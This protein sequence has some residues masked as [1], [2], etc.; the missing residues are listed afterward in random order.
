[1]AHDH[2]EPKLPL[3]YLAVVAY[4]ASRRPQVDEAF[5]A[6][7]AANGGQELDAEAAEHEWEQRFAPM[8]LKRIGPSIVPTE[9][10][11]PL[12]EMPA[13]LGEIDRK[14]D[15][16]FILEGMVGKGDKVVLLGFIPHDERTL[17]FNL[18]FALSLSVIKIAKQ[19]GG[20]AYSTGLYFRREA[21]SVLG[22]E[23]LAALRSY[24]SEVDPNG[25]MNPGKV[26]GFGMVDVLM[27]TA[28]AFESIVRPMA[29]AAKPPTG[30]GD[31]TQGHQRHSRRRGVHGLRVRPLR[32][33]RSDVRAVFRTRLGVAVA[34]RQVRLHPRGARGSRAV[35]PQGDRHAFS[36]ARPARSATRAASCSFPSSTTGWRCAAS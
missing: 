4:P 7:I 1:M 21:E 30:P 28:T 35:G 24:K 10:V 14:L 36:C 11:V 26:L 15:Q 33:L 12:K 23:K 34:A 3:K 22:T 17:A 6:I 32:L 8:R 16:P 9:V 27:G 31:L 13:V 18:A 29:N 25:L 20:A 2:Y 19:H 5:G